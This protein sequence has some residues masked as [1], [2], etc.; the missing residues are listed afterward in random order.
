MFR[1]SAVPVVLIAL[2]AA[3][4][5]RLQAKPLLNFS[6]MGALALVCSVYVRNPLSGIGIVLGAR[7]LTDL[8]LE[9]RTGHGFYSSMPFEY[10]AYLLMYLLG[11]LTN[12]AS[13][14]GV[15]GM[16]L[17]GA[18]TFFLV[19]NFGVWC[20]PHEAQSMYPATLSGLITCLANGLPF[21]RGTLAGDV[22]FTCLFFGLA[23]S[24]QLPALGMTPADQQV[25]ADLT[26]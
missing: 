3:I 6:A 24:L 17:A 12:P 19:S 5:L 10:L 18:L 2:V 21:V 9:F 26:A 7:L 11:R 22:L 23:R 14:W 20:L 13:F 8:V 16:S 15:F 1:R 4:A 25:P